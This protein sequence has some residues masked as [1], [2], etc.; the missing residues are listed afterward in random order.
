MNWKTLSPVFAETLWIRED[1]GIS[2]T[3]GHQHDTFSV[4]N[5]CEIL[6]MSGNWR[7]TQE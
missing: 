3:D 6:I 1:A 4:W 5:D 7:G 2:K